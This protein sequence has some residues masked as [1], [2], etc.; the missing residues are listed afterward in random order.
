M[1]GAHRGQSELTVRPGEM[2]LNAESESCR[3]WVCSCCP[4]R[5]FEKVTSLKGSIQCGLS[6]WKVQESLG[7]QIVLFPHLSLQPLSQKLWFCLPHSLPEILTLRGL[8][9][10][11]PSLLTGD[12]SEPGCACL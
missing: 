11:R 3:R 2:T 10:R 5:N 12:I 6:S 1:K 9:D 4:G 8:P 7:A